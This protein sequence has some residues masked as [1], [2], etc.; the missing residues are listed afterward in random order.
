MADIEAAGEAAE[1]GHNK[2]CVCMGEAGAFD[3]G[4][5][6]AETDFGMENGRRVAASYAR[7]AHD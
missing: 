4:A 6:R 3:I 5:A 7:S 2:E 1:G